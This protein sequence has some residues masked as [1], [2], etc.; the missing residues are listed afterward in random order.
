MVKSFVLALLSFVF[1]YPFYL[2]ADE[3]KDIDLFL[4]KYKQADELLQQ[5]DL[6]NAYIAFST[7]YDYALDDEG[8]SK[9]RGVMGDILYKWGDTQAAEFVYREA[10]FLNKDNK[11]FLKKLVISKMENLSDDLY[12]FFKLIP[13]DQI[14]S[15][16][17]YHYGRYILLKENKPREACDAFDSVRRES[18]YFPKASYM[19][20]IA[21]LIMGD[22]DEAI[23][24]FS[25]AYS[26][27]KEGEEIREFS[28]LAMGRIYSDMGRFQDALPYYLS[29]TKDSPLFYEAR[30][31]ICWILFSLER[32]NETSECIAYFQGA[33]KTF[34]TKRLEVLEA[35]LHMNIDLVRSFITFTAISDY[36]AMFLSKI[37]EIQNM[38]PVFWR[39]DS[40]RYFSSIEPNIKSWIEFLPEYKFYKERKDYIV[41]LKKEIEEILVQIEKLKSVSVI[42]ADRTIKRYFE[43]IYNIQSRI[44]NALSYFMLKSLGPDERSVLLGLF[45]IFEE[46]KNMDFKTR[47]MAA[48]ASLNIYKVAS[49]KE[50]RNWEKK[51]NAYN[52]SLKSVMNELEK[53]VDF[54]K[55]NAEYIT[56]MANLFSS[57]YDGSS[58]LNDFISAYKESN[59]LFL[60]Y[61]E[62]W[63][64]IIYTAI[65]YVEIQEKKLKAVSSV[66]DNFLEYLEEFEGTFMRYVFMFLIKREVEKTYALA[67]YGFIETAWVMKERETDILDKLHMLRLEEENKLRDN[68]IN[69]SEEVKSIKVQDV[70]VSADSAF[71][72]DSLQA[73]GY[74]DQVD[75]LMTR[76]LS[77][78]FRISG[79][80]WKE[81]EKTIQELVEEK[82]RE[83]RKIL[84]KFESIGR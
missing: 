12:D 79:T 3:K 44:H 24:R 77:T 76:S 32:Y 39:K 5:G 59:S 37:V 83:K 20:G 55:R 2:K 14:D 56:K 68:F 26:F 45:S 25:N 63:K 18:E 47:E 82:E 54:Q 70:S 33:K 65:K 23:R 51:Y 69:F 19:C 62:L 7:A 60:S 75:N 84:E 57:S 73:I 34:L 36:S 6:L 16:I 40:I 52:E 31:E 72:T 10:Y 53:V 4:T 43:A 21:M 46:L 22:R 58:I 74:I 30:Y 64:Q 13:K 78:V 71:E 17:M 15:Q 48:L 61:S 81:P 50:F 8:R 66:L 29:V 49:E 28:A 38:S 35:F 1:L 41:N 11:E 80:F 27:S 9:V 42:V 67:R